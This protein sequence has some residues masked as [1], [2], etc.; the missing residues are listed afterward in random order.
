VTLWELETK[1]FDTMVSLNLRSGYALARAVLPAMLK[2]R[3]GS[4][5]NVAAKA[6]FDHGAA[7]RLL[8]SAKK[9]ASEDEFERWPCGS[10]LMHLSDQPRRP[11]RVLSSGLRCHHQ[12]S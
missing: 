7:A 4:I 2:Q 8:V 12:V 3:H 1:V 5:V 6:A 9:Y 10:V 11:G